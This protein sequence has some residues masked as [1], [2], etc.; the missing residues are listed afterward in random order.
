MLWQQLPPRYPANAVIILPPIQGCISVLVSLGSTHFGHRSSQIP[1][2]EFLL[3]IGFVDF[4]RTTH[5]RKFNFDRNEKMAL[6]EI[7]I[8]IDRCRLCS[9]R[10]SFWGVG[11]GWTQWLSS[12]LKEACEII[13]QPVHPTSKHLSTRSTSPA[14]ICQ[15]GRLRLQNPYFPSRIFK[16]KAVNQRKILQ[17]P[18]CPLSFDDF[19]NYRTSLERFYHQQELLECT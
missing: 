12:T 13:G 3:A 16:P 9:C 15:L 19:F 8:W 14:S 5:I 6:F 1:F 11:V 4:L 17:I 2:C 7:N 10:V 18:L